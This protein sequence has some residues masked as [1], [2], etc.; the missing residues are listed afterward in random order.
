MKDASSSGKMSESEFSHTNPIFE[1][2]KITELI[3]TYLIFY[4]QDRRQLTNVTFIFWFQLHVY[5][6]KQMIE[7]LLK[8][9][10]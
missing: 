10:F 8:N 4:M 2:L 6:N 1:S 7:K 5:N 3:S 9:E